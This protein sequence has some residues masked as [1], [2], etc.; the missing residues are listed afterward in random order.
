MTID[1][2][3]PTMD[4]NWPVNARPSPN[5]AW[6]VVLLEKAYA[7]LSLNYANLEGG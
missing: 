6:W 1:D 7:K 2:R 4:N 5:G 3:V